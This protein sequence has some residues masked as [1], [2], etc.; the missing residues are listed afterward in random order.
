MMVDLFIHSKARRSTP[1]LF[2]LQGY[3]CLEATIWGV[4]DARGRAP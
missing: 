3:V 1:R 4:A 2:V